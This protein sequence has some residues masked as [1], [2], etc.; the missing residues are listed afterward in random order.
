M[1][2]TYDE[3][4]NS[5]IGTALAIKTADPT[6]QVSGPVMDYWWDYFYSKK[7]IADGATAGPC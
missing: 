7:D 3:L 1:P 2:F 4:T 5:G 6:A